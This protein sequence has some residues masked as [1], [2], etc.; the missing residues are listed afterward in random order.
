MD[1]LKELRELV[2]KRVAP[3]R[4]LVP[5]PT[6]D[7]VRRCIEVLLHRQFIYPHQHSLKP[8]HSILSEADYQ[9]FFRKYFNAMGLEFIHDSRSGMVGL[10]MPAGIPRH[11]SNATRLK[12][13]ETQVIL[14]LR[15]VFEEIYR[16]GR[17]GARGEVEISSDDLLDKLVVVA[18][19]EIGETRLAEVL[20]RF[21]RK[22]LVEVGDRDPEERVR[23]ITIYPGI[24]HATP[25]I[26]IQRVEDK[27]NEL[28]AN[29]GGADRATAATDDERNGTGELDGVGDTDNS[30]TE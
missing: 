20:T 29:A 2:D 10:R 14:I 17:Q 15:L 4:T 26:F 25:D 11:N 21:E 22:G 12:K 9:G 30:E 8:V 13:D 23:M 7:E 19:M 16:D 1:E 28:T 6:E 18:D 24:E 5:P 3:G 27:A